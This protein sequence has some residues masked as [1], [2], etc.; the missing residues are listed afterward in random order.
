[1]EDRDWVVL[2]E[3]YKYKNITRTA[4][5]LFISQPSLTKRLRHIEKELGVK[6][7]QRGRRGVH[8]TPQGEYLA[9]AAKEMLFNLRQ[10]KEQIQNIDDQV[11]G[12]L[13]LG[14]SNY[15][16]KFQLPGILKAFKR[17]YPQV[18]FQVTTGWSRE[19]HQLVYNREVHI[20]FVR[21][22][23]SWPDQ[24]H[25]LFEEPIC[26]ASVEKIDLKELPTRPRINYQTEAPFQKLMDNWWTENYSEP[27]L[28]GMN[29][30]KVDTCREMIINGLGYAIV[31]RAMLDGVEDVNKIN[32]TDSAGNPLLR[33]TWMFYYQESLHF[34]S[35][36]AFVRFM[37]TMQD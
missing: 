13:R 25:L 21:G 3:L 1:M 29:V 4:Q 36:R 37:T 7:V 6:I 30:D 11:A 16:T 18:E 19:V 33:Q 22:D 24:K 26:I 5:A 32:I 8:F 34:H 2:R 23:Y 17:R 10:I 28:V 27:P 14:V 12:P 20:G 9:E 31:P 35:V 15:F